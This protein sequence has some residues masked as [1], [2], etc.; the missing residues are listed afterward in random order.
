MLERK[1]L[2]GTVSLNGHTEYALNAQ[3]GVKNTKGLLSFTPKFDITIPQKR[4]EYEG[5]IEMK[6]MKSLMI[7]MSAKGFIANDITLKGKQTDI[8]SHPKNLKIILNYLLF[9]LN[10]LRFYPVNCFIFNCSYLI[11]GKELGIR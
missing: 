5:I 8:T 2:T 7:D 9:V 10:N 3:L 1:K 11:R 6:P 4:M